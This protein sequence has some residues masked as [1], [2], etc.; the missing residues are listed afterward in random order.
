VLVDG[1][2][3][4]IIACSPAE[5][6]LQRDLIRDVKATG[7]YVVTVS[8]RDSSD[9]GSDCN[10]PVPEYL[11]FSVTGV[12]FIY[13]PQ[14]LSFFKALALGVNPD[15]PTGLESWIKL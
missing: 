14:A 11:N 15:M 8:G 5:T 12:P 2:S 7:A 3:L 1:H 6:S 9:W 13:V 10:I 4:V